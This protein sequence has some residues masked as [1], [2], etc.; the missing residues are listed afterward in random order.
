MLL[1]NIV[2]TIDDASKL[3]G[4][5][6]RSV[7]H[8]CQDGKLKASRIVDNKSWGVKGKDFIEFLYYNP[9][10]LKQLKEFNFKESYM[11]DLKK[12]ILE[13]ISI[14][15]RLYSERDISKIFGI[16]SHK[17]VKRWVK[18]DRIIPIDKKP[19]YGGHLFNEDSIR[20]FLQQCP[21]YNI[22]YENYCKI[23]GGNI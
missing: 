13:R 19:V 7:L 4:A 12:I 3:T 21:R 2:L 18:Y 11:N 8:W 14:M 20:Y 10:Y 6:R 22:I 17:T 23:H 5:H 15:P 1:N 16:S 9:R